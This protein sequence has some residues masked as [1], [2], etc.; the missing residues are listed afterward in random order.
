MVVPIG[1]MTHASLL[2]TGDLQMLCAATL[3]SPHQHMTKYLESTRKAAGWQSLAYRKGLLLH[4]NTLVLIWI[5]LLL[6]KWITGAPSS[7]H[8]FL[9]E[10]VLEPARAWGTP[11][12]DWMCFCWL[13]ICLR[14]GP[15]HDA[16]LRTLGKTALLIIKQAGWRI[17]AL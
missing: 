10:Y 2:Q 7:A 4:L 15:R 16:Q 9:R 12:I 3:T 5:T 1:K 8:I 14:F 11:A 17:Y 6:N 13:Y